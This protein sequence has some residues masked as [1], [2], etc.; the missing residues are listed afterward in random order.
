VN[1]RS[2]KIQNNLISIYAGG[3]ITADSRPGN[4]WK[5]VLRKREIMMR[6]VCLE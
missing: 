1:L 4:E 6:L 2:L 5:E 3:G